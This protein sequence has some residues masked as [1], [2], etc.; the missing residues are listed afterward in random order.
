MHP[1]RSAL[2]LI[3]ALPMGRQLS[4]ELGRERNGLGTSDFA[5]LRLTWRGQWAGQL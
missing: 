1:W 3:Q 4:A 5:A 2:G